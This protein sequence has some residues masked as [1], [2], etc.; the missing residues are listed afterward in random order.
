M[1]RL[2]FTKAKAIDARKNF[3]YG[4]SVRE[5]WFRD[6]NGKENAIEFSGPFPV[7]TGNLLGL[8]YDNVREHYVAIANFSTEMYFN[9][10]PEVQSMDYNPFPDLGRFWNWF[11]REKLTS[12]YG[13]ETVALHK[14]VEALICA[15][16][17]KFNTGKI[18]RL[19]WER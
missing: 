5:I 10:V 9:F 13:D 8:V 3:F 11:S 7:R 15:E 6:E 18:R 16:I 19:S 14:A 17:S 12:P 4:S 2:Q 1:S